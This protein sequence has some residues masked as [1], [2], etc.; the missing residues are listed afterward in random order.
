VAALSGDIS[1]DGATD[2]LTCNQGAGTIAVI[3]ASMNGS[4]ARAY[5]FPVGGRPSGVAA[6]DF[7]RDG[8]MD[9][10]VTDPTA[11]TI[12]LLYGASNGSFERV[13]SVETGF[14]PSSLG[15][16]DLNGDGYPDLVT[17]NIA[18]GIVSVILSHGGTSFG[19]KADITVDQPSALVIA[20]LNGDGIL[21]LAVSGTLNYQAGISCF[22]GRGDGTF[23]APS[24]IEIPFGQGFTSLAVGRFDSDSTLDLVGVGS[25]AYSIFLGHGDGSFS[26]G[27]TFALPEHP[28]Q[29]VIASDLN[30]DGKVDLVF[31]GHE[32][33]PPPEPSN[34]IVSVALGNGDGTF[35]VPTDFETGFFPAAVAASDFNGDGRP[36][37]AVANSSGNTVSLLLGNGGG[38]FGTKLDFGT[39]SYPSDVVAADMDGDGKVDLVTSDQGGTVTVLKNRGAVPPNHPPTAVAGGPYAGVVGVPVSFSGARSSDPEGSPL[40]FRWD[41]GDGVQGAGAE[42]AHTYRSESRFPVSLTVSDGS[43]EG[44]DTTGA[45]IT[46]TLQARAFVTDGRH[47]VGVGIGE[48]VT[49]FQVEPVAGDYQNAD[50]TLSS[51]ILK[52]PGTGIVSEIHASSGK[53]AVSTDRDQNGIAEL[54]VCFARENLAQLFRNLTGKNKVPVDIE[55]ALTSGARFRASLSLMVIAPGGQP[56]SA[57]SSNPLRARGT[58]TLLNPRSGPVDVRIFDSSGRLV[59]RLTDPG[60]G[61]PGFIDLPLDGRSDAGTLLHSGVYFYKASTT[62]GDAVG[63]FVL[64]R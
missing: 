32:V 39:G 13:G 58:L 60:S 59:R 63:R 61:G 30:Q 7:N 23:R 53:R 49:Y 41:F 29:R 2:I 45:E 12:T 6:A 4:F 36:D 11:N 55:G 64:L 42:P 3:R 20:D 43:L 38:T 44:R 35:G 14:T 22:L 47:P 56:Y 33:F 21:D 27:G 9:L 24:G 51:V 46:G 25:G 1:L 52:S 16:G 26:N 15:V 5:G 50:V 19:P 28:Y 34:G 48:P 10:A 37:L 31:T 54:A 62:S 18:A 40:T 57:V 17:A 8:L